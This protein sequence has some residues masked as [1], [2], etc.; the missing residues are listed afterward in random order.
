MTTTNNI[1]QQQSLRMAE[2]TKISRQRYL[3]AGG[4]P[5]RATNGNEWMTDE[6]RQE[7][8]TLARQVFDEEALANYLKKNGS[9]R[10]RFAAFKEK[11][12]Q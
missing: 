1:R 8:L 4:D 3:D 6:E 9:W 10:D 7:Y 11:K 12:T 2:L 5:H